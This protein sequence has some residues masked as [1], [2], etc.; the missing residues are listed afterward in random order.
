MGHTRKGINMWSEVFARSL[1]MAGV[2]RNDIVQI[3]SGYGLFTGGLGIHYGMHVL[4]AILFRRLSIRL[5]WNRWPK[6]RW[7]S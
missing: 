1:C 7:V 4:K 2:Y 3:A 5:R 6:E